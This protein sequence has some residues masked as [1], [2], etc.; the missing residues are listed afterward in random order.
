MEVSGGAAVTAG[1]QSAQISEEST[2][3]RMPKFRL[4]RVERRYILCAGP[5]V[6]GVHHAVAPADFVDLV[7]NL[8]LGVYKQAWQAL[9]NYPQCF[10]DN[11]ALWLYEQLL[12]KLSRYPKQAT[13]MCNPL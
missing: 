9:D 7:A 8:A 3:M 2:S 10:V 12:G 6:P 13:G 5:S 1:E 4:T 11:L